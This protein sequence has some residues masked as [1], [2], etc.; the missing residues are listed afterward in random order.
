MFHLL[1]IFMSFGVPNWLCHNR[2]EEIH[3][4]FCRKIR[5]N[6]SNQPC[7]TMPWHHE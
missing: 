6:G 4:R 2:D 3:P 1:W 7:Q 5:K